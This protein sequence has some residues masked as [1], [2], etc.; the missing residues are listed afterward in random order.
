MIR[1]QAIGKCIRHRLDVVSIL[2]QEIRIIFIGPEQVFDTC[3]LQDLIQPTG[4]TPRTGS[5]WHRLV[6]EQRVLLTRDRKLLMHKVIKYGYLPRS[7]SA[8]EQLEEVLERFHLFDE[9]N[10]WSRCP[11]CN[12]ILQS[13]PKEKVLDRLEPLT[14]HYVDDFS[15]CPGCKQ[16]YWAGSHRERMS[17]RLKEIL[18]SHQT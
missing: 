17:V 8:S 18:N 14:K 15:Q 13:V 2:L 4:M 16:V 5:C 11:H 7:D 9:V 10:P 6:D 12:T 1:H 3:G